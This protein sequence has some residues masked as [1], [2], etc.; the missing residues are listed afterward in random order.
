M[1]PLSDENLIKSYLA[2][3]RQHAKL[4]YE[5]YVRYVAGLVFKFVKDA[6]LTRDLTQDI[7]EKLFKNLSGFKEKSK[8]KTWFTAMIVNQCKDYTGKLEQRMQPSV[9]SLSDTEDGSSRDLPDSYNGRNPEKEFLRKEKGKFVENALAKLSVEHK[10]VILLWNEGFTYDEIA[11]ITE[12]PK[13]TVGSRISE[14]RKQL[15][16]MLTPYMQGKNNG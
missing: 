9:D 14:A 1:Q 10:M 8:F 3:N 16:A 2:G 11:S 4:L 15:G 7:F 13:G 12:T 5:R 6:E